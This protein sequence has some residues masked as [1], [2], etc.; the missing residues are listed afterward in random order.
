M[1]SQERLQY[2]KTVKGMLGKVDEEDAG[3]ATQ[4]ALDY[5]EKLGQAQIPLEQ[6]IPLVPDFVR[7]LKDSGMGDGQIVKYMEKTNLASIQEVIQRQDSRALAAENERRQVQMQQ[8]AIQQ[9]NQS[10]NIMA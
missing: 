3:L 8:Q 10:M 2:I 4:I 7:E 1:V 6:Y 9:Y 5:G